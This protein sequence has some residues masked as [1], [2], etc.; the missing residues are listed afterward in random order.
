VGEFCFC[1]PA[2]IY[3]HIMPISFRRVFLQLAMG[4]MPLSL[5]AFAFCNRNETCPLLHDDSQ[6]RKQQCHD[7]KESEVHYYIPNLD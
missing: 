2:D 6:F 1:V 3:F 7:N 5:T 4:S